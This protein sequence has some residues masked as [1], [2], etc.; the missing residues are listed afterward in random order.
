MN[1]DI[2][3]ESDK[4]RWKQLTFLIHC[5]DCGILPKIF[6]FQTISRQIPQQTEALLCLLIQDN[7][8]IKVKIEKEIDT[9]SKT[10][11][12]LTNKAQLS[13]II[14]W[15]SNQ[16]K[17]VDSLTKESQKQKY[18]WLCPAYQ[19]RQLDPQSVV[20]NINNKTLSDDEWEVLI[21]GL[22]FTTVP[23]W[24]LYNT[25]TEATFRQLK[26]DDANQLRM[27]VS[28]ALHRVKLPKQNVKKQLRCAITNLWNDVSIV[29][30]LADKGNATV[31]INQQE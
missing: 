7:R 25:T 16:E 4:Q 5:R 21:L 3:F 26:S 6:H 8:A 2:M 13:K 31:V 20:K 17:K 19:P 14:D 10:L 9:Y 29:I 1:C 27:E 22:N 24:I 12:T 11:R 15:C 18:E 28:G 23:R 30:L